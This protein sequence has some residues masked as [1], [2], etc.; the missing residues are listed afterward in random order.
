MLH[1]S[2]GSQF[3]MKVW[4]VFDWCHFIWD[5]SLSVWREVD[6]DHAGELRLYAAI[7]TMSVIDYTL[8]ICSLQQ[9]RPT[10]RG[11]LAG[12]LSGWGS[13]CWQWGT[14]ICNAAWMGWKSVT[15]PYHT[16]NFGYRWKLSPLPH[17]APHISSILRIFSALL[18]ACHKWLR[19]LRKI[20][21]HKRITHTVRSRT[22]S[23][24]LARGMWN[25][26]GV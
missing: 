10:Y 9:M 21:C 25:F 3:A 16:S 14:L 15:C 20:L 23:G 1:C 11:F 12:R 4:V 26:P 2:N 17:W 5:T 19:N 24:L 7:W 13:V 8:Y 22:Y 18:L 6:E